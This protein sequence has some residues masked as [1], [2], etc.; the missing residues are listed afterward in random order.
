[1]DWE[2]V[3]RKVVVDNCVLRGPG[4]KMISEMDKT[5]LS[6]GGFGSSFRT[7]ALCAIRPLFPV[8][9]NKKGVFQ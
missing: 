2:E 3:E 7:T 8:V 1:M 6:Y 9:D 4:W 5:R